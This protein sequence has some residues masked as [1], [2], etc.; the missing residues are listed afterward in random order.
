MKE[1]DR[2]IKLGEDI[3]NKKALEIYKEILYH[4]EKAISQ[5]Y[6]G[7]YWGFYIPPN[8][9]KLLEEQGL[10][11]KTYTDGEFEESQIWI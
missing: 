11:Y 9:G 1:R 3:E 7:T 4:L 2:L 5:G 6:K 8:V 10:K